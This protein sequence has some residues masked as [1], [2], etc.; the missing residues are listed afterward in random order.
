[1]LATKTLLIEGE[2]GSGMTPDRKQGATLRAYDKASGREVER[3]RHARRA[4]GHADDLH[5]QW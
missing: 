1:M 5:A 2:S 3:G 4:D